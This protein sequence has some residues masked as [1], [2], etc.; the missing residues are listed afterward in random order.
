MCRL[1]CVC[2]RVQPTNQLQRDAP[3]GV[4]LANC[5]A[6]VECQAPPPPTTPPVCCNGCVT[7]SVYEAAFINL[8]LVMCA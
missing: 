3:G 5:Q 8:S 7:D 1:W 4:A 6:F 2:T